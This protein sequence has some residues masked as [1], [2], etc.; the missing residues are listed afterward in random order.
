MPEKKHERMSAKAGIELACVEKE[1]R[2]RK[3]NVT[4]ASKIML[5]PNNV[6]RS[7]APCAFS[8][9]PHRCG[10]SGLRKIVRGNTQAKLAL[11]ENWKDLHKLASRFVQLQHIRLIHRFPAVVRGGAAGSLPCKPALLLME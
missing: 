5:S 11:P 9:L 6:V 2:C 8:A 4:H 1:D 7:N 10:A 3:I